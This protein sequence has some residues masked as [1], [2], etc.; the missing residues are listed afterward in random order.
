MV[1]VM[2]SAGPILIVDDHDDSREMLAT[3]FKDAGYDVCAA[4]HGR[5]ALDMLVSRGVQPALIILDRE[6]SLWGGADGRRRRAGT[7]ALRAQK[8][9]CPFGIVSFPSLATPAMWPGHFGG[10]PWT[11]IAFIA[12]GAGCP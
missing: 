7:R 6:P 9:V 3:A 12:N 1:Q 5:V 4:E 8:R 11:S 10:W 2:E